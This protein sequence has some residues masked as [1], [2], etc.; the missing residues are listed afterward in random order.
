M[1]KKIL[2]S[3]LAGA[4]VMFLLGWLMFGL[5]MKDVMAEYMVAFGDSMN[6]EPVMWAIVLA[7]LIMGM[8]LAYLLYRFG[9]TD[10]VG[11]IKASWVILLALFVW[12]DLWMFAS[13]KG[14]T[15]KLM[16]IDIISNMIIGL[17]GAGVVGWVLGK[18]KEK[19]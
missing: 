16:A 10:F 19:V 9:V 18:L 12:F 17:L 8:L 15:G 7:N 1:E 3:G 5:L 2:L 13:F 6:T 4:V 14:M 11:G